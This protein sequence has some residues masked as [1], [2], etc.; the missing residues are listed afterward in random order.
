MLPLLNVKKVSNIGYKNSGMLKVNLVEFLKVDEP[1]V[2]GYKVTLCGRKLDSVD[3]F[4]KGDPFVAVEGVPHP[5]VSFPFNKNPMNELLNK[6]KKF[7]PRIYTSEVIKNSENP[8]WESFS[9]F[10]D[11]VGDFDRPI[12]IKIFDFHHKDCREDLVGKIETSLL[13]LTQPIC[14]YKLKNPKGMNPKKA[15]GFLKVEE[16]VPF[17]EGDIHPFP[18]SEKYR[19]KIKAIKIKNIEGIIK[20]LSDHYL[21]FLAIPYGKDD[22]VDIHTTEVVNNSR[23]G[24]W[25]MTF[26]IQDIGGLDSPVLIECYD[27]DSHDHHEYIGDSVFTL[28]YF[29]NMQEKSIGVP[30]YNNRPK[31][32][33]SKR[34]KAIIYVTEFEP[35]N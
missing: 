18:V 7:L 24:E 16:I 26:T 27:A 3:C 32:D 6:T 9:L 14:I 2:L 23:E 4:S 19:L 29:K 20:K 17:Q 25:E 34:R 11:D 13:E 12:T 30:L 15:T 35:V 33:K 28:R 21:K 10:I 22:Y 1:K 31:R 8:K 5:K